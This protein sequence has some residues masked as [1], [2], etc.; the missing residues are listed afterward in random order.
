M[1]VTLLSKCGCQIE[2]CAHAACKN[3][4]L[5]LDAAGNHGL[6]CH[7][8]VKAMRATL[9]EKAL[10][11]GFRQAGGNPTKQPSTYSLLGGHFTKEDLSS[12][13]P[14][15][16]N[17]ADAEKLKKLAVSF[18]DIVAKIPRGSERTAELA[19]LRELFPDPKVARDEDNNGTIQLTRMPHGDS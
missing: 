3:K 19:K 16:L 17:Q 5:K 14:G 6:I 12:L 7:P 15:R 2:K 9:L 18:L 8:G 10:E 4:E 13:F 1:L 11:K